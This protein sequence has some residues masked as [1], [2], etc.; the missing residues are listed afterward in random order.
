VKLPL[1]ASARI[2]V[3][4]SGLCAALVATVVSVA[5]AGAA[6]VPATVPVALSLHSLGG[7]ASDATGAAAATAAPSTQSTPSAQSTQSTTSTPSSSPTPSAS[8]RSAQPK[9]SVTRSTAAPAPVARATATPVR[10][11]ALRRTPTSWMA[12]NSAIG[13]IPGY[14]HGTPVHWVVTSSF[15]H[16]GMTNWYTDTIY[17]SPSIPAWQLDA[18]A[19]HEYGHILEARAYGGDIPRMIAALNRVYGGGGRGNLNGAEMA[20][21][22]IAL[23]NGANWTHYTTCANPTWRAGA[24]RIIAGRPA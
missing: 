3:T 13:R 8:H 19:R 17:L 14:T 24:R 9:P 4:V 10:N 6:P 18:V 16:L 22:C 1:S 2:A 15:G 12:L 5:P 7:S 11:V 20:A 21:D 23:V